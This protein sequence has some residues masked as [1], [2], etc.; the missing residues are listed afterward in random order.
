MKMVFIGALFSTVDMTLTVTPE[1]VQEILDLVEV[2]LHKPTATLKEL[3]SLIGKLSFVAS[4]VQSIRV[5]IARLL[6]W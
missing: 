3:Q 2:W 6:N 5:L 4:Y 1:R